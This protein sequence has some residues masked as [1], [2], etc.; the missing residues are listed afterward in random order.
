MAGVFGWDPAQLAGQSLDVLQPADLPPGEW[1]QTFSAAGGPNRTR[2]SGRRRDGS[3]VEIDLAVTGMQMG[4]Q[5]WIVAI[6][7][8]VTERRRAERELRHSREEFAAAREVQQRLFPKAAP[9]VPASTS[10]ESPIRPWYRR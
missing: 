4:D 1:L 6:F 10:P 8:D 5:Q 9:Q 2:P 7:R 3:S